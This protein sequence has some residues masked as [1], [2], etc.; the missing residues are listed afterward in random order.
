MTG[1]AG[2]ISTASESVA[3]AEPHQTTRHELYFGQKRPD[4]TPIRED[5]FE[6]FINVAVT[7]LFPA[8]LTV[9][10]AV[11]QYRTERGLVVGEST[12]V[13]V[14]IYPDDQE[15]RNRIADI[16]AQYRALFQ[17]ESVGWVRTSACGRF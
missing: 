4:G 10:D 1:C 13:L 8:G 14:L 12:K 6:N 7:P 11:G 9:F 16:I 2:V 5:E 17:Q 3:C 15:V